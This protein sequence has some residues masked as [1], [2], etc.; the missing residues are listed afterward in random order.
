MSLVP[1]FAGIVKGGVLLPDRP[2]DFGQWVRSLDGQR[3]VVIV[4]K[5]QSQRSVQAN[6]YYFG[7]I[8]APLAEHC[9]YEKDDMHEVLAMRFLRIEDCPITGA[10]RR[11]RTPKCDTA[12]FAA[13]VDSCIRLAAELGVVVADP[14]GVEIA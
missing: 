8:V 13:Y 14:D 2:Q 3:V 9:G 11:K 5:R 12:E 1:I 7:A 10:P 6:R 4:K